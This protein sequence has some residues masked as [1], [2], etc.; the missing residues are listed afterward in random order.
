MNNLVAMR[1]VI[2]FLLLI[3]LFLSAQNQPQVKVYV[4]QQGIMKWQKDGKECAFFGVNYTVPFAYGYRSVLRTGTS[5]EK[6]IND[7]VYHFARL[8]INAFRVHVWDTEITDS[9]GNLL[10]NEHLRLFDYL[11]MKLEQRGI[12]TMLTPLAFW[13]NGYPEPDSMTGSFSS[14][15]NK[16]KVLIEESAIIAQENYLRQFMAHVNPYT[17]KKFKDD[18]FIIGMEINNEP[19]HSG[20]LKQAADYISRMIRA[21]KDAG[22]IKP[23]FYK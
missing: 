6:A 15:Y 22:W 2:F 14:R 3:P 11:L 12:H 1:T 13:G 5:I 18:P 9:A 16:Q 23:L 19:H 10:E 8:G 21:V 17:K 4:D 20:N 7:D